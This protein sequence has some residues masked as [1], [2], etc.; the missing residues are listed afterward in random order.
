M[1]KLTPIILALAYGLAMYWFSAWRTKGI[2]DAQ[3]RPMDDPALLHLTGR[4]AVAQG[5]PHLPVHVFEVPG[6]NGLA[7]PDGRI[8]LTRGFIDR[9]KAGGVSAEELAGVIA[10][11]LGHVAMGHAKRR[12]IDVTGQNAVFVVLVPLLSRFVPVLGI[13]I[14]RFISTALAA[15]LSRKAEH[16]ADA[17]ASALLVKAGIGTGPQKS[18]FRKL[19]ALVGGAGGAPDWLRSH[20]R[21]E[22]RIRLIEAREVR[23]GLGAEF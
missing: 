18:L 2:L 5:V 10:H 13:W 19:D 6:V 1:L 23:W 14:A 21:T 9:Y 3:S 11:E 16:E 22:E 15:G 7:A 8:F 4:L 20:P 17:Y 12:M